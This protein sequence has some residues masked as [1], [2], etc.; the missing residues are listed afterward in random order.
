MST[1]THP[2]AGTTYLYADEAGNFDFGPGGTRHFLLAGV[3]MRRPFSHLERLL[4]VKYDLLE[5]G[6]DLDHFHAS[7]DRQCVRDQVFEG[8]ASGGRDLRLVIVVAEKAR[9]DPAL[10]TPGELY[11]AAFD[12][13]I[14]KA[15]GL[16]AVL[17]GGQFMVVTDA[18]PV[19]RAGAFVR[20]GVRTVLKSRTPCGTA[21]RVL[22]HASRADLNLQV[23]DYCAWAFFRKWERG[24]ERS[25]RILVDAGV[26]VMESGLV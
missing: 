22:H 8:I 16:S 15:V 6:L 10:R 24:D 17:P 19:R 3:R 20:K 25:S 26:R 7:E 11:V 5:D 23:A 12:R 2:A 14:Q 1:R 21:S 18:L 13:L 9:L 4:E